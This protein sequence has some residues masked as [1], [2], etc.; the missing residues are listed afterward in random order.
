ML[1]LLSLSSWPVSFESF[2]V[3]HGVFVD[4]RFSFFSLC[5]RVVFLLLREFSSRCMRKKGGVKLF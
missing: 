3:R 4:L 1:S 5:H 2:D